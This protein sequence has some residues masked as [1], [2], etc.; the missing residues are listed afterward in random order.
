MKKNKEKLTEKEIERARRIISEIRSK[1][2]VREEKLKQKIESYK[3]KKE[4]YAEKIKTKVGTQKQLEKQRAKISSELSRG[5][6]EGNLPQKYIGLGIAKKLE[7]KG[8]EEKLQREKEYLQR[9]KLKQ[10]AKQV[11]T[12]ALILGSKVEAGVETALAKTT[13]KLGQLAKQ[14]IV[15]RKILKESKMSYRMPNRPVESVWGDENRFFRGAY[16]NEKKNMFFS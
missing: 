7:Y 16:N 1:Q 15:S 12:K 2:K 4:G 3:E 11:G 8:K 10:T 5:V 9:A 14:K 13:Q 6:K